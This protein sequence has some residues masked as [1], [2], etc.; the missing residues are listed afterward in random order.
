MDLQRLHHIM[1]LVLTSISLHKKTN[2]IQK[3]ANLVFLL[4]SSLSEIS[5][6]RRS[7]YDTFVELKGQC[8]KIFCLWFFHESVSPQPKSIPLGPFQIFLKI[9]GRYSQVKV[10]H[11]YQGHRR[12]I[13]S[14]VLP[15]FFIPVV[16]PVS[17]TPV[18]NCHRYQLLIT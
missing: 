18:A 17:M 8:H 5:S 12:N 9:R 2:I 4:L 6:K 14:P 11:R 3:M 15:V 10:L 16:P 7:L 1:N 13:L